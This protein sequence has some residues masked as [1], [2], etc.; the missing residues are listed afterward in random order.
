MP[1]VRLFVLRVVPALVLGSLVACASGSP[2]KQKLGLANPA[3]VHCGEVG[4]EL[5]IETMGDRGEIGICYFM[6]GR[7]CEE[8]ALFRGECPVGGRR[9]TGLVTEGARY[10]A[11]RGGRYEMTRAETATQ[12]EQGRCTLPDGTVCNAVVSGHGAC[13]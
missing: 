13:P 11:I 9:V 12:P 2:S 7:Q 3:S 6:D 4:G 1:R 10:C 8:W 5:R